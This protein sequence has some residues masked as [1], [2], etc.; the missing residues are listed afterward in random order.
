MQQPTPEQVKEARAK[1]GLTQKKAGE[2]VHAALKTWQ[3]W[4]YG[5]YPMPLVAWELF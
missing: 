2:L 3:H 1:A 4:E 5:R